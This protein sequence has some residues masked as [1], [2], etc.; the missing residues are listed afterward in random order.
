MNLTGPSL[1]L[2]ALAP[3]CPIL[4][5]RY[6]SQAAFAPIQPEVPLDDHKSPVAEFAEARSV[7]EA[8]MFEIKRVIVGQEAM[9]ERVMVALLAGG[10]LLLEGVPGLAK[11]LTVKTV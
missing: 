10:H 4:R 7:F 9:L 11:T 5:T 6:A 2:R 8:T 3:Q 1:G